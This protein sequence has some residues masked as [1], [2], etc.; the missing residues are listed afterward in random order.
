MSKAA[1]TVRSPDTLPVLVVN[2]GE[3]ADI[4]FLEFFASAMRNPRTRRTYDLAWMIRKKP[5]ALLAHP[6]RYRPG[7][8]AG[9][10]ELVVKPNYFGYP[11][12]D[13]RSTPLYDRTGQQGRRIQ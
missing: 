11:G 8:V 5:D 7:P 12:V 13:S 6:N 4:R 9:T 10:C 2:A 1:L 3:R